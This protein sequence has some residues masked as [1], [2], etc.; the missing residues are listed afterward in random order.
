MIDLFAV[1]PP[2]IPAYPP[3]LPTPTP[4]PTPSSFGAGMINFSFLL[5]LLIWIPLLMAL[6]VSL[7]PQA[8]LKNKHRLIGITFWTNLAL[9]L[10][11]LIAYHQFNV[12]GSG[13]QFEERLNWLPTLGVSYHLGV[14]GVG[15]S[16][17]LLSALIGVVSTLLAFD[18]RD[19]ERQ[20]FVLLLIAQSFINGAIAA[21]NLLLLLLFWSALT[22]PVVLLVRGWGGP[23]RMRAA[24]S[25]NAYWAVGTAALIVAGLLL[26]ISLGTHSLE[27]SDL[28]Q[29]LPDWRLQIV[30]ASLVVVAAAS[31]LALFPLHGGTW[32]ALVTAHPAVAVL[33]VGAAARL[34]GDLLFRLY[35]AA[36]HG[37]AHWLA[38]LL[39]AAAG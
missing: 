16:M 27:L 3:A 37:G 34:G 14:S 25:L 17:L 32:R 30:I 10:I 13:V 29:A 5:S 38:P 26:V 11:T 4:S 21:Q 7:V 33:L 18:L 28:N 1:L 36:N 19:R 39:A 12:Y 6:V 15:M 8:K 22:L 2:S 23:G 20:F 24:A 31:R 35:I 9:L